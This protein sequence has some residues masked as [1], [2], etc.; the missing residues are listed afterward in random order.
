MQP[1]HES[2]EFLTALWGPKP[3]PGLLPYLWAKQGD[4]KRTFSLEHFV[5]VPGFVTTW[6]AADVYVGGAATAKKS[7]PSVRPK[8]KDAAAI[9]GLWLDAD[10]GAGKCET[11]EDAL[12]ITRLIEEPSLLVASGG[13]VHAWWLFDEPWI[14][15]DDDER[16]EAAAMLAGWV[17]AHCQASGRKLDSVGEL[18]RVMRL[19]GTFNQKQTPE[20]PV[21]LLDQTGR[22][23]PREAFGIHARARQ[24]RAATADAEGGGSLGELPTS[25]DV[26]VATIRA[27]RE[28]DDVF[29][30]T[31]TRKRKGAAAD[32][33][34]S[35]YDL[36]ILTML[37]RA[38]LDEK[39]AVAAAAHARREYGNPEKADKAERLD[40]WQRTVAR[41]RSGG[42][43]DDQ[44]ETVKR[45]EA[46]LVGELKEL[47]ETPLL[48]SAEP[49]ARADRWAKLN[50]L[51]GGGAGGFPRVVEWHQYGTDP[52]TA[53]HV[54]VLTDGTEVPIGTMRR[55]LDQQSV[56]V[57]LMST[58]GIMRPGQWKHA[59]WELGIHTVLPLRVFH[60]DREE[61]RDQRALEWVSQVVGE[62][63]LESDA[64]HIDEAI[65]MRRPFLRDGRVYVRQQYL[66]QQ[67]RVQKIVPEIKDADLPPMLKAA[68]FERGAVNYQKP[69]GARSTRSYWSIDEELLP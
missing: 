57:A 55:I 24:A 54:W 43:A 12:A 27:M 10:V 38:G 45:E 60:A 21:A 48:P 37:L 40:Y 19:P 2:V 16:A 35:E 62:R 15:A 1:P 28:A 66:G 56:K 4:K 67:L 7:A 33:S 30:R 29:D 25:D 5:G 41:A 8:A 6:R 11:I 31:W 39:Q 17:D 59:T 36:S 34:D 47:R 18:G 46:K 3:P 42:S 26:P 53:K 9:P 63:S 23:F 44:A 22:V 14:F 20:R 32:W 65:Q 51:V 68:G 69:D 58:A 49:A 61:E 13:G 50:Q 52:E 64:E